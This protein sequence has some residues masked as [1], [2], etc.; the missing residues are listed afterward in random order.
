V[1]FAGGLLLQIRFSKAVSISE[2]RNAMEAAGSKDAAVQNFAWA[3]EF[4][5]AW[6]SCLRPGC[7]V[8]EDRVFLQQTFKDKSSKSAGQGGGRRWE[9]S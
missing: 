9:G 8:Q 6:R 2:V 5:I 4:L 1:D 3:S 7:G